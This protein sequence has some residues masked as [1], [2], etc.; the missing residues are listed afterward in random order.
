M[1]FANKML[2]SG[3]EGVILKRPEGKYTFGRRDGGWWKWKPE[4]MDELS[5]TIDLIVIGGCLGCVLFVS[6]VS[7]QFDLNY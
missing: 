7:L 2:L 3:H 1:A 6:L 4:Y 5:D